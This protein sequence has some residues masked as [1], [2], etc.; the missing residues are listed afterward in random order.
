MESKLAEQVEILEELRRT[1]EVELQTK[2]D[3][4]RNEEVQRHL[5]VMEKKMAEQKQV[6]FFFKKRYLLCPPKNLQ[7]LVNQG[8]QQSGKSQGIV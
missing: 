7:Q 6:R 1:H 4:V 8:C 2:M 3:E 5:A